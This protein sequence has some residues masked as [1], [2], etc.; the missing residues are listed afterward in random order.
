MR[1]FLWMGL[2]VLIAACQDSSPGTE[3]PTCPPTIGIE[4]L[5]YSPSSCKMGVGQRVSISASTAHPLRGL[6]TGNP[7]PATPTTATQSY[8]FSKAGT[9]EYEC[10]AHSAQ[11]MKG[12][13]TVVGP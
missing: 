5:A 3:L 4:G 9:Y 2:G 12:S 1:K 10:S 11:G 8:T 13:I 6:G 7:I